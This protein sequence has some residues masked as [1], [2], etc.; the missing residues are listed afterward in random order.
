MIF[1]KIVSLNVLLM[2]YFPTQNL[3]VPPITFAEETRFAKVINQPNLDQIL[4]LE[5][6]IQLSSRAKV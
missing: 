5:M 2:E 6:E 3:I 1:Q 4:Y